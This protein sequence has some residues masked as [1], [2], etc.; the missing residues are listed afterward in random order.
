M[1]RK[2]IGGCWKMTNCF[3]EGNERHKKIMTDINV[4]VLSEN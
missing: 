4:N 3:L 1:A 2:N